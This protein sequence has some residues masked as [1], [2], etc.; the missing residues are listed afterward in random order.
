MYR[1]GVNKGWLAGRGTIGR[2]LRAT[3]FPADFILVAAMNPC[4]CGYRS[5]SQKIWQHKGLGPE[6]V[7][8]ARG[9]QRDSWGILRNEQNPWEP[10]ADAA[11][12]ADHRFS[13][14]QKRG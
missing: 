12:A 14:S 10:W 9:G 4:P 8:N 13:R 6:I 3:T 11:Q 5:R 1:R 2:G 7:E